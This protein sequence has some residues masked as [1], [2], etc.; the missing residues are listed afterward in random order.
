M[1]PIAD[2]ET[3]IFDQ[4]RADLEL[5]SRDQMWMEQVIE[6]SEASNV[7]FAQ[8]P[9][10]EFVATIQVFDEYFEPASWAGPDCGKTI[11]NDFSRSASTLEGTAS[12]SCS[13]SPVPSTKQ[14]EPTV[15][16]PAVAKVSNSR[17]QNGFK[18]K[19][20]SQIRKVANSTVPQE[21]QVFKCRYCPA[22]FQESQMLGGH[23]SRS[24]PGQSIDYL[25]KKETRAKREPFRLA[26]AEAAKQLRQACS[27]TDQNESQKRKE[28]RLLQ[29]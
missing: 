29:K 24:H 11:D 28:M 27:D 5:F 23:T 16:V 1:K 6:V 20:D 10:E 14:A 4:F 13:A 18:S 7:P 15:A 17:R 22:T 8:T 2:L 3:F 19:P 26:R 25:K 21:K 9:Q 12:F